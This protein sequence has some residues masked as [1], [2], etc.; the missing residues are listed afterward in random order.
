MLFNV[1]TEHKT[2]TVLVHNI[3]RQYKNQHKNIEIR[4]E[5]HLS[6]ITIEDINKHKTIFFKRHPLEIIMSGMRYH[7]V[8]NEIWC[9]KPGGYQERL[10]ALKTDKEKIIFEMSGSSYR[11]INRIYSELINVNGKL[12]NKNTL[13]LNLEEFWTEKSRNNMVQKIYNHLDK[14]ISLFILKQIIGKK[15]TKK[16]HR[17]NKNNCYTYQDYF[18]EELYKIFYDKFP[19]DVIEVLGYNK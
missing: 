13:V 6:D 17:T 10:K 8:C 11:V 5:Q 19:K 3:F 16:F 9:T 4:L 2:G 7:Q 15:V 18:D 14:K 12:N 1:V